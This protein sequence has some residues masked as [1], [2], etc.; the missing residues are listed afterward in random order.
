MRAFLDIVLKINKGM[1]TVAATALTFIVFLTTTDVVLRA[2]GRPIL[3]TYE[4]V[5]ICGGIV[6][7]FA[8]PFTSWRRG[9]IAVDVA[10]KKF[11]G[12]AKNVINIA[13]RCVAMALCLLIGWNI[14]KIGTDFWV[15]GEVSN[16]LQLP[17]YPV[18]Y[19]IAACFLV[20]AI[21]LFCDILKIYRGT[22]E[23]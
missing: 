14:I 11:S 2:M 3:G 10:F 13:T 17:L 15:G 16:T 4:I 23:Q 8:A 12:G 20:L 18:A 9:H 21:V 5:A 22:Y 6:I 7:G 19:A 1:I